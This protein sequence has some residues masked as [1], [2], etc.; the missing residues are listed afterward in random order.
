MITAFRDLSSRNTDKIYK[1]I[2]QNTLN[3][4]RFYSKTVGYSEISKIGEKLLTFAPKES[5]IY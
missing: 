1:Y 3:I 4:R 2:V 5:I